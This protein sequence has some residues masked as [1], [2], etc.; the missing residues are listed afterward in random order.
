MI[1]S[2]AHTPFFLAT[3]SNISTKLNQIITQNKRFVYYI[4]VSGFFVLFEIFQ[5]GVH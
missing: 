5:I 1:C 4:K 2:T 3:Y